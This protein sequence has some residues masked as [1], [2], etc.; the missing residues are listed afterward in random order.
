MS[1]EKSGDKWIIAR[2]LW[3]NPPRPCWN[4]RLRYQPPI[5][6]ANDA[7][8][9]EVAEAFGLQPELLPHFGLRPANG[10]AGRA[11]R[12]GLSPPEQNAN[13][14]MDAARIN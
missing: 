5:T 6:S 1:S 7:A 10:Q 3:K 9:H 11:R 13:G 14:C 4:H 12:A 8:R 2:F